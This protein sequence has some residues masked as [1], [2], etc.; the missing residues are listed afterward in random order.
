MLKTLLLTTFI[1]IG[2]A[3][4]AQKTIENPSFSATT[5]DYVTITHVELQDTATVIDF[6]VEYFPGWWIQ[7][8]SDKTYIQNSQGGEKLFVNSAEGIELNEKHWTPDN[9][10][11][12]Y[13]LFFHRWT[14][15]F[16]PL[17]S[18]R[19]TGRYL[20]LNLSPKR[21]NHLSRMNYKETGCAPME[22]TNGCTAFA[23]IK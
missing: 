8:S 19:K 1:S 23:M 7:V 21:G 15:Q 18:R 4:V 16:N 13:T 3:T 6:E 20:T 5:S 22:A 12:V 9:G 2:A 14:A 10:K 11:N 17:I